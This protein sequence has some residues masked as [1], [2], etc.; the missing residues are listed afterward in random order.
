MSKY[1][2]DSFKGQYAFLSNFY[3]CEL[4][5]KG[6]VYPSMEHAFQAMKVLSM[7]GRKRIAGLPTAR[8]ARRRGR[9]LWLRSG[10]DS[11]RDSIMLLFLRKKFVNLTLRKQL[12]KTGDRK[13]IEGNW[14]GDIY[15]GVC[16]G[17]GQ[18]KL[19]KLLMQVR[20]ECRREELL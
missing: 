3:P 18:N 16:K 11:V 20:G 5:H 9:Q 8:D 12:L 1:T 4:E 13:L 6:I 7:A 14:W 17:E 2:I 19:G 10:W 15:W